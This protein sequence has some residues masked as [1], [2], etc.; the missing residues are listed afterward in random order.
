MY[1]FLKKA[2]RSLATATLPF[3]ISST[4]IA[5]E[6]RPNPIHKDWIFI[7]P[8]HDASEPN[9]ATEQESEI[10]SIETPVDVSGQCVLTP[11]IQVF[12]VLSNPEER[13]Q[14][15]RLINEWAQSN[16]KHLIEFASTLSIASFQV[17]GKH[18]GAKAI[19]ENDPAASGL[20]TQAFTQSTALFIEGLTQA[21]PNVIK[22]GTAIRFTIPDFVEPQAESVNIIA[23][24]NQ[25]FSRKLG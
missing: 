24:N 15:Q 14:H 8:I 11:T 3:L 25:M 5:A 19:C 10:V 9:T 18:H 6:N 16:E 12:S 4:A 7:P 2:S 21:F 22:D 17:V 20:L 13:A 1:A 23:L